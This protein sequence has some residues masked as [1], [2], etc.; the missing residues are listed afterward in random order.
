MLITPSCSLGRWRTVINVLPAPLGGWGTVI[1]VLPA[2]LGG[3][4]TV[5]NTSSLLSWVGEQWLIPPSCSPGWVRVNVVNI[6][7]AP[8][9]G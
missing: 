7:P 2:L 5:V 1:N 9:G 8:M 4:R 3:W 6:L